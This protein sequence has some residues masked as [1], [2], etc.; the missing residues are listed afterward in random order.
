MGNY[1]ENRKEEMKDYDLKRNATAA[2]KEKLMVMN[3]KYRS[4]DQGKAAQKRADEMH[5]ANLGELM[6]KAKQRD[7]RQTK[8]E[9]GRKG[10]SVISR[11]MAFQKQVLRGPE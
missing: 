10:G 4:T 8:W 3:K 5:Q 1:N 7:Y 2:R 6:W 11:R 9:K